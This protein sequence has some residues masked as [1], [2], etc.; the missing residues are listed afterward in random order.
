MRKLLGTTL[1]V[2]LL[3]P[4]AIRPSLADEHEHRHEPGR[5]HVEGWHGDIRHFH[6]NDFARWRGGRWFHGPH[7]GRAGWWWIVG[8]FW[9]FYPAPVYP[10]PDPFLPPV[11]VVEPPAGPPAAQ[12]WYYCPDPPGYYPYVPACRTDWQA[13]SPTAFPGPPPG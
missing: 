2:L 9:Y 13:V 5:G 10:F 8:G 1:S 7:N 6:E 3:M 11:A 4:I 12:Y